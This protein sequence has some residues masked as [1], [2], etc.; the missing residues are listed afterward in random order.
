M[1]LNWNIQSKIA[2]AISVSIFFVIM[3]VIMAV[4]LKE[5]QTVV[6]A[7][8]GS[9]GI[10]LWIGIAARIVFN[11]IEDMLYWNLW[12]KIKKEN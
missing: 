11:A 6:Y 3:A 5:G 8:F 12:R 2:L 4:M 9:L 10:G 1:K 7:I